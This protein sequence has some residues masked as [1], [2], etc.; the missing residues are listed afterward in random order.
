MAACGGGEVEMTMA[1]GLFV[2]MDGGEVEK[3]KPWTARSHDRLAYFFEDGEKI[4][5]CL[6]IGVKLLMMMKMKK[7]L[8]YVWRWENQ[9]FLK[10]S[11]E[12]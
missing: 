9:F 11:L 7:K 4:R 6:A 3:L 12:V 8:G 10:I 2:V 5:A 1:V